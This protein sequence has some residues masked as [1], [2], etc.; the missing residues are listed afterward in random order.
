MLGPNEVGRNVS[1]ERSGF[2][3]TDLG[4]ERVSAMLRVR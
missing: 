1:N 3:A 2:L 4:E